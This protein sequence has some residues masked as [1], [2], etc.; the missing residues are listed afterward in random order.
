MIEI[1]TQ[2]EFDNIISNLPQNELI[3]IWWK[4]TPYVLNR[5]LEITKSFINIEGYGIRKPVIQ[6]TGNTTVEKGVIDIRGTSTTVLEQIQLK[7][8][9][10]VGKKTTTADLHGIYA[11]YVGFAQTT[12]LADGGYDSTT[13]GSGKENK[14]GVRVL[15]CIIEECKNRGIYFRYSFNNLV[16]RNT[17]QNNNS[18]GIYLYNSSHST[19]AG[20]TM[21]DGNGNGMYLN[22]SSNNNIIAEN[23]I[24]NNINGSGIYLGGYSSN[25]I[26]TANTI[27]N[28]TNGIKL[29][30]PS[31][32][33]TITGNIIQNTRGD[34][35]SLSR[36]LRNTIMG[37]IIQNNVNN[38]IVLSN[39]S[40]DNTITANEIRGNG[41]IGIYIKDSRQCAIFSNIIMEHTSKDTGIGIYLQTTSKCTAVGNVA[42][43]NNLA[44]YVFDTGG[45]LAS[46]DYNQFTISV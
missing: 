12:G 26:V 24:Q 5:P 15:D 21:Q 2:Q 11:E 18:F 39:S 23:I 36:S 34:G 38:G 46:K 17:I 44:D 6:F 35:L 45:N 10:I 29:S 13:V 31:Y 14:I 22:S 40:D 42:L 27:Q 43:D 19:V 30:S 20:N 7:N 3:R 8:L 9:H 16:T 4:E 1:R 41:E 37:N 28:N 33:N 32:S 25:N